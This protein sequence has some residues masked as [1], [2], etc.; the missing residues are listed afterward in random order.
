M[1]VNNV[2][3]QILKASTASV[4]HLT[5]RV[6]VRLGAF[7]TV[8][9]VLTWAALSPFV[10]PPDTVVMG[11]PNK[12]EFEDGFNNSTVKQAIS[13]I[14]KANET[15]GVGE[16]IL[17]KMTSPGGSVFDGAL[18]HEEMTNSK[19]PIDVYVPAIA[20]SMG[21]DTF[22]RAERR[23]AAPTA[24]ILFHGASAG[25][26]TEPAMREKLDLLESKEFNEY[27]KKGT[28]DKSVTG[29]RKEHMEDLYRQVKVSSLTKVMMETKSLFN[30]LKSINDSMVE[31]I[32]AQAK[33]TPEETRK[34]LFKDMKEDS[35]FT[36]A[37]LFK[38]GIIHD[39]KIPDESVYVGN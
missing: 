14:R 20:A 1:R 7:S 6:Q 28:L 3:S 15:V 22:M 11:S 35:I 32:A 13:H 36:G 2:L 5:S 4:K 19:V 8:A 29:I 23:Y 33:M 38:M 39:T 21:A 25:D 31:V 24:K 37:E 27:L 10:F 12:I 17:I 26:I 9:A 34:V 18:L 16:R 30:I